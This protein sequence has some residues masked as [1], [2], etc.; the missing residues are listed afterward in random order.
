[1]EKNTLEQTRL[2]WAGQISLLTAGEA[3]MTG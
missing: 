1:M 3:A 2:L